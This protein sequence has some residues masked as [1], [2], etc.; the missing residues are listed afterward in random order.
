MA[1]INLQA[2]EVLQMDGTT[3]PEDMRE[4]VCT[5]LYRHKEKDYVM[6]A[7]R[8]YAGECELNE[9]EEKTIREIIAPWA[10]IYRDAIEKQLAK[11]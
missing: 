6:F 9:E 11:K 10:W 7:L 4:A 2:V 5:P 8:L 1:K 3:K